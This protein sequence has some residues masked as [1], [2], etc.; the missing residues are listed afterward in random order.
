[1]QDKAKS[2]RRNRQSK[3]ATDVLWECIIIRGGDHSDVSNLVRAAQAGNPFA[4]KCLTAVYDWGKKWA[5]I[6]PTDAPLCL[7]CDYEFNRQVPSPIVF[8]FIHSDDPRAR[9]AAMAGICERCAGKPDAELM[10]HMGNWMRTNAGG[11]VLGFG[12]TPPSQGD[13]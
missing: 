8:G 10:T 7:A 13:H 12:H 9:W 3:P 6:A 5:H 4:L 11:R 2:A 1:L